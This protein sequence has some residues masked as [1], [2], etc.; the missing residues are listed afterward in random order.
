M[1]AVQ[2]HVGYPKLADYLS[3]SRPDS[4][5]SRSARRPTPP[6]RS[7]GDGS[8][9][10]IT[11]GS[12]TTCPNLS[13]SF[14][15]P[16]GVNVPSYFATACG[17][18]YVHTGS[19]LRYDTLENPASLYPLDGDRY[20]TGK[21]PTRLGGD[22]WATDAALDVM[23][24]RGRLAGHLRHLARRRQGRAHVGWGR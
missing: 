5:S 13:G 21:D 6:G 14:R 20:T 17:R 3:D 15:A 16:G 23:R 4:R 2:N 18:C 22:I 1:F 10:I 12:S 19:S 7:A 9:S 11:F 24:Q 8:D